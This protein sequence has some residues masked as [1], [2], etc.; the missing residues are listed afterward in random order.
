MAILY[1]FGGYLFT[2]LAAFTV[3]CLVVRRADTEDITILAGLNQRSP[4]LATTMTLAMVSLA[5]IPPLAGFFGKFLLL[6]AV[7]ARGATQPI[8]YWLIA[9]AIIGVNLLYY[10]FGVIRAI[11]GQKLLLITPISLLAYEGVTLQL[12]RRNVIPWDFSK[13]RGGSGNPSGPGFA[14]G[15]VSGAGLSDQSRLSIPPAASFPGFRVFVMLQPNWLSKLRTAGRTVSEAT[16]HI[17]LPIAM[18]APRLAIPWCFATIRLPN[19]AIVLSPETRTALPVLVAM[20]LGCGS[21]AN[22]F[23]IWM[24]WSLNPNHK[25][26]T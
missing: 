9:V 13:Q 11:I 3:I 10:Y 4:L 14:G 8:Y 15:I 23:R 25:G 7:I 5:G 2:V 18:T 1:Y 24:P 26:Q 17:A 16:I 20:M 6:K 19:P 22:R 21:S 12:Y